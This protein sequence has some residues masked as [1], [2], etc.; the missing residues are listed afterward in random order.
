MLETLAAVLCSVPHSAEMSSSEQIPSPQQRAGSREAHPRTRQAPEVLL[1]I[2]LRKYC[3][4][5]ETLNK[6]TGAPSVSEQVMRKRQS[7]QR[8][9]SGEHIQ[10]YHAVE[11][12]FRSLTMD[13]ARRE[14]GWSLIWCVWDTLEPNE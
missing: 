13:K 14:G 2:A 5:Q 4:P 8:E 11:L 6:D 3:S 1:Q 12:I 9:C 10:I 7:L